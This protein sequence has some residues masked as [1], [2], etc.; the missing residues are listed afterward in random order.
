MPR[1]RPGKGRPGEAGEGGRFLGEKQK[2]YRAQGEVS[3]DD[4][5]EGAGVRDRAYDG[6]M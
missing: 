2:R 6:E 3:G 5:P 4:F 1:H